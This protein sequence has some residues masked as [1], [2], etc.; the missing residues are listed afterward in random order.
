MC[1]NLH[2]DV[3]IFGAF[4][5]NLAPSNSRTGDF[6][7]N[8]SGNP[9]SENLV[10]AVGKAI[11]LLE[12]ILPRLRGQPD[13]GKKAAEEINDKLNASVLFCDRHQ[14]VF[15]PHLIKGVY[16]V[17]IPWWC[18]RKNAEIKLDRKEKIL[19]KKTAQQKKVQKFEHK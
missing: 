1:F 10:V 7:S 2:F 14:E 11:T 8:I 6:A 13:V 17:G 12:S 16:R 4:C 9:A 19:K 15:L 5:L 3:N 18:K